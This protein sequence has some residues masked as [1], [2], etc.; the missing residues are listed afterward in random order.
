MMVVPQTGRS[1]Y[2]VEQARSYGRQVVEIARA[3]KTH[4]PAAQTERA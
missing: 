2:A 3:L 4:S 1:G